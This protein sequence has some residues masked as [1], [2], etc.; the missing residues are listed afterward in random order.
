MTEFDFKVKRGSRWDPEAKRSVPNPGSWAVFLPHQ[1]DAW[2]IAGETDGAHM[3]GVPHAEAVAALELFI[4]EA[5][6]ALEAL[7]AEREVP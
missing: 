7:K 3:D 1:C 2:D 6:Q 5:Q 4:A